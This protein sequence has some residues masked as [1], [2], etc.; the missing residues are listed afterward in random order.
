VVISF[1]VAVKP[2]V[3]GGS[4]IINIAYA[5]GQQATATTLIQETNPKTTICLPIILK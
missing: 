5:G 2:D 1:K 3:G 4:R